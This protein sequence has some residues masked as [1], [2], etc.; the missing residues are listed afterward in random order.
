MKTLI[1]TVGLQRDNENG[2]VSAVVVNMT[3]ENAEK[4]LTEQ[5]DCSLVADG[6]ALTELL[7]AYA[8]LCGY[9]CAVFLLAEEYE[10]EENEA[11]E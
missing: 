11:D 5:G 1:I 8:L 4:I 7:N 10:E 9:Q 2:D 3:V 6:G